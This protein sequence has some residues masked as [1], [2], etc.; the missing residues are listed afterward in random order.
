MSAA[1]EV[2]IQ[3]KQPPRGVPRKYFQNTFS[4]SSKEYRKYRTLKITICSFRTF[5]FCKVESEVA[6]KTAYCYF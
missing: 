4:R 5:S 3:Q 1:W 2:Y 6:T